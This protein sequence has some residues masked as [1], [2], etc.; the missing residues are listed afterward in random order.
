MLLEGLE[1]P[2]LGS[3]REKVIIE[4]IRRERNATFAFAQLLVSIIGGT[5]GTPA[6]LV[7]ASLNN[8]GVELYQERYTKGYR[9]KLELKLI[10]KQAQIT[11]R[12][13]LMD[14]LDALEISNE[15][16]KEMLSDFKPKDTKNKIIR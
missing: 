9:E 2:P 14:R 10:E 12:A 3:F 4:M 16:F 1:V 11:E 8:Y 5:F 15:Q 6:K 7:E 13:R